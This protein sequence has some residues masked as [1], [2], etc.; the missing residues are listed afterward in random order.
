MTDETR[1]TD[2][3]KSL[4]AAFAKAPER[5][6]GTA[7][8][9]ATPAS[10]ER[11]VGAQ[12]VAVYRNEHRVLEKLKVL[13]AAAGDNWYYRFPVKNRGAGTT[14]WIEGPT[15]KLANDLAREYGNC[16]IDTRVTDLGDSWLILAR[17]TDFETGFSMTRPFQQRKGQRGMGA[18]NARA[19]DI[20][21][22]IGASKAIR[23]VIVNALQ[24]FS[25]FAFEE[26]RNS[27]ID[28]IGKN[29]VGSRARALERL[30]DARVE[31]A[32]AE[33]AIGR[34]SKDWTAPD[35][36]KIVAML[37]AVDDGMATLDDTFPPLEDRPEAEPPES[38]REE[39]AAPSH[40]AAAPVAENGADERG[41]AVAADDRGSPAGADEEEGAVLT[42]Y[43]LGKESRA[44]GHARKAIPGEYRDA[45]RTREALAWEAGWAGQPMPVFG[46]G[47]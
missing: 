14:D 39:T 4:L 27:L 44:K 33:R 32:R 18:D 12:K 23:N 29:L 40:P 24:T 7:L 45:K 2:E 8:V 47:K 36:A 30:A 10:V 22:Q 19:L 3:R 9:T 34:P 38:K 17:F 31:V 37:R 15:I 21:L 42:A 41:A 11:V 13:A 6:D 20:N 46:G 25:D 16:D 43:E 5:T 35:V 28:K 1:T 26:A